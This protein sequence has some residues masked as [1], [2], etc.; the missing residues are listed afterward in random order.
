ML[1]MGAVVF[2]ASAVS[3]RF[4]HASGQ[5]TCFGPPLRSSQRGASWFP[6]ETRTWHFRMRRRAF[7]KP[8]SLAERWS[9]RSSFA[10]AF[11]ATG[12]DN[13]TRPPPLTK[14]V[15]LA[16]R[17]KW[18]AVGF[19]PAPFHGRESLR[20]RLSNR[21]WGHTCGGRCE[22]CARKGREV[23]ARVLASIKRTAGT[24]IKRTE[25]RAC[26]LSKGYGTGCAV[27]TRRRRMM[28]PAEPAPRWGMVPPPPGAD[29]AVK[30]GCATWSTNALTK[31]TQ[32]AN[33]F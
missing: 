25:F 7:E 22:Q 21:D 18:T 14:W 6:I 17:C 28:V 19:E 9:E 5:H 27:G 20:P 32:H 3:S 33:A 26:G 24:S 16:L 23:R 4:V 11:L 2:H 15:N 13:R 12:K 29:R 10:R 31:E 30:K 1:S 8:L